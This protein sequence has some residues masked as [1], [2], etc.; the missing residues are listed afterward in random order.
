MQ[1]TK[2]NE[3]LAFPCTFTYKVIGIAHPELVK[4]VIEIVQRY[5]QENFKLQ[6]KSSSK[7]KY[8]SVSITINA[9]NINQVETLYEELGNLE[10]VCKVL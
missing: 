2:L 5:V 10:L 1:K 7:G 6:V 4:R 9:T 8:H 3:L